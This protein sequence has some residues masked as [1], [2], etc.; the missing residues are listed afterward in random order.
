MRQRGYSKCAHRRLERR[1][2]W[3]ISGCRFSHGEI[4]RSSG[5]RVGGR[6]V[7][8]VDVIHF[9]ESP[10]H[11]LRHSGQLLVVVRRESLVPDVGLY[12]YLDVQG[13]QIGNFNGL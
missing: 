13:I 2:F 8:F 11:A 5:L 10:S 4:V 9:G 12:V 7:P 6:F 3:E 1:V